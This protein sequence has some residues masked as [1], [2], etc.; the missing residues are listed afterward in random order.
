MK[1]IRRGEIIMCEECLEDKKKKN[2]LSESQEN[3][4]NKRK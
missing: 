2:K 1:N 4:K 3:T